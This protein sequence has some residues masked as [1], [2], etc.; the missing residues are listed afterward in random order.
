MKKRIWNRL[1]KAAMLTILAAMMGNCVVSAA[2]FEAQEME[3]PE[4]LLK[5]SAEWTDEENFRAELLLEVSGLKKLYEKEDTALSTEN[6]E[7]NKEQSETQNETQDQL[8]NESQ[9]PGD[10]TG[11][12]KEDSEGEE[13]TETEKIKNEASEQEMVEE[14]K[15]FLTAY[16]SEYFQVDESGLEHDMQAESVQIK[17]Q[18]GETTEITK[19]TCEILKTEEDIFTLK[20]PVL[21]R[22]E[23]RISP[24]A[25]SCP[26]C[27]DYPLG[28][29]QDT[30]GTYV[31]GK[32]E[33]DNR[34]LATAESSSLSVPEAECG[35]MAELQQSV[36]EVKAGQKVSYTLKINNTGEIP[37]ENIEILSSFSM[38]DV[39]AVW[40]AEEGFTANA[41]QG[42]LAELQPGEIRTLRLT[43]A[44]AENQSGELLH[45]VSVKTKHPGKDENI[46]SRT[47]A[48]V[49]VKE[50]TA[51]FEVEKTADRT[52]A[53]P[54][55][56]I[57]YQICI[58]NTGERT[59]HS[60][61]STER[62]Q[63]AGIQARFV[64]KEGVT[65]NGS[66]TQAVISQ[67]SPGEAFA[68][69][70]EVT[71][72]QY[73]ASQELVNEVTVVSEETGSQTMKS[74]S[75][76]TLTGSE[77]TVT[78][79]PQPTTVPLQTYGDGGYTSKSANAYAASSKPR[80]GDETET[81]LYIVLAVWAVTTGFGAFV[82]RK[83]RKNHE[84]KR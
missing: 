1:K 66:G 10:E 21:L 26:V 9:I 53:Y 24:V 12:V 60:V 28:T 17:N 20:I 32:T 51:A 61:L 14:E 31:W 5:Q 11:A 3:A 76:V 59:L 35:I 23:Y 52:E 54:G 67:L 42:I 46:E 79:T 36:Q 84:D 4:I 81:V 71:I 2:E 29:D 38:K 78:V 19:L 27:Q 15:Y 40:E 48:K 73:L 63:N 83:N 69:Y 80:T 47:S 7:L 41:L 37:L 22:T 43:A 8:Q 64:P 30:T 72:P 68:L 6:E 13:Q 25:F 33:K 75:E 39:S 18:R 74:Q 34:I 49:M 77:N 45:T 55:D 65:I 58:R 56:T 44:P 82:Y 62:F 57:T 50:L 70:A 16:I